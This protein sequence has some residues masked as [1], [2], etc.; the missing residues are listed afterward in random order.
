MARSKWHEKPK[1]AATCE[2]QLPEYMQERSGHASPLPSAHS[3]KFAQRLGTRRPSD[4]TTHTPGPAAVRVHRFHAFWWHQHS[5]GG[6]YYNDGWYRHSDHSHS[7]A[8]AQTI[9]CCERGSRALELCSCGSACVCALAREHLSGLC[10]RC[11][12]C[13]TEKE[14]MG[15]R[16]GRNRNSRN[17]NII[18]GVSRDRTRRKALSG[19]SI[20]S[21]GRVIELP[22]RNRRAQRALQ[23]LQKHPRRHE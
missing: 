12:G 17:T 9:S 6:S 4:P 3:K 21:E 8:T 18:H 16:Y 23:R 15:I 22:A 14:G 1:T 2:E 19:H 20:Y 7:C 13:R 10:P 5:H 11:G